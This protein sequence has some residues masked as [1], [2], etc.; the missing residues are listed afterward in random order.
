MKTR[1]ALAA[2]YLLL[3]CLVSAPLMA[4]MPSWFKDSFLYLGEEVANAAAEGKRVALYFHQEECPYCKRM[5]EVNFSQR[6]I[7]EKTR[8]QFNVI[9][10]NI[11]G[12]LEVTDLAG[13][14]SSEKDFARDQKVQFTPTMIFLD[15]QGAVTFRLNG[16]Y[17]PERFS[18]LLDY[19]AQRPAP[20]GSFKDFLAARTGLPASAE[21]HQDPSYLP[22]PLKLNQ[23]PSAKPLLLLFEQAS[24]QACDELHREGLARDEAKELLKQFDVAL[25]DIGS[26]EPITTPD[27]RELAARDWSRELGINYTPTLLFLDAGDKEVFR[28]DAYIRPYHIATSLAYVGTGAYQRQPEFQRFILE[29][30]EARRSAGESGPPN[31]WD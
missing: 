8:A 1:R 17:P 23:R 29:R 21:L 30:I 12:D 9:A 10:I 2:P 16:Y 18:A 6:D 3:L 4:S 7:V 15:E 26:A 11:W 5:L 24:C 13:K 22:H 31:L 25:V 14:V 20:T 19:S 28:T 27:G